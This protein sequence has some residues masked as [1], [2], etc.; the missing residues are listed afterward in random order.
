M[1]NKC[2]EKPI[3]NIAKSL[4]MISSGK[5][6]LLSSMMAMLVNEDSEWLTCLGYYPEVT[7]TDSGANTTPRSVHLLRV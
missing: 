6:C 4:Y 1:K 3:G 5:P 2:K 7:Y